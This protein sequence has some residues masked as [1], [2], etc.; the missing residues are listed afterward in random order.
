MNG[1]GRLGRT[2]RFAV[3]RRETQAQKISLDEGRLLGGEP[4]PRD[5]HEDEPKDPIRFPLL[6]KALE[7][8]PLRADFI[9][10]TDE[11]SRRQNSN[12]TPSLIRR[13]GAT[14]KVLWDALRPSRRFTRKE[15]PAQWLPRT[16]DEAKQHRILE[17][18][19][20]LNG[21][22][23]RDILWFV[24]QTPAVVALSGGDGSVL[25]SHVPEAAGRG[26]KRECDI[27]GE[28]ALFDV[29]HDGTLDLVA[30]I[31]V[32]ETAA[33]C[34]KRQAEEGKTP[35][36]DPDLLYFRRV[37]AA[38]SGQKGSALWSH[39]IDKS[40]AASRDELR[41]RP[42][43]FVKAGRRA[44]LAFLEGS[45]WQ[46]LDPETGRLVAGPLELGFEP[47]RPIL[48]ADCDG[49]GE[50][51][52]LALGPNVLGP[53]RELH[54]FSNKTG[55]ELWATDIG[56]A[57]DQTA[58]VVYPWQRPFKNRPVFSE[59]SLAADLDADGRAEIVVADTGAMPPLAGER[60]VRLIDGATG[61][62]RW[63]VALR[64]ENNAEDGVSFLLEAPDLDGDGVRDVIAVSRYVGRSR[65]PARGE[66]PLEPQRVFVDALSGKGGRRLW[67][68]HVD[69]AAGVDT[70]VGAPF[71]W[72][73]GPDG[74]PLLALPLGGKS[75][76]GGLAFP[77]F[78]R[79]EKPVVHLVEATTGRLRHSVLGLEQAA[80]ADLNGDGLADLWGEVDGE[81]RA[82]RGE[83]PEAWRALGRFDPAG[84]V[85][86]R[87]GAGVI[88]TVDLNGDGV[89]DTLICD[90]K[91]PGPANEDRT[92]SHT[93][94]ARSGRDGRLIWKTEIDP[95]RSWFNPN[96]GDAYVLRRV[97]V[98]C[99][100][101]GRRRHCRRG[102]H[103]VDV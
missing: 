15:D 59:C 7:M 72:S 63:R 60:G 102:R 80:I 23:T 73:R 47:V 12:S 17:P 90:V 76:F 95:R 55:R 10:L 100:R 6:I 78:E 65:A 66:R 103:E 81:L 92:G 27:A 19:V 21:D 98:A 67:F 89:A 87:A 56:S 51:E 83:V 37:V 20:D 68:W 39:A 50:P 13:D 24:H 34:Q 70:R 14:G 41:K 8:S 36:Q 99:G 88:H 26:E 11:A 91:A 62:S 38:V 43:M 101:S 71:W 32:G 77:R 25:W 54:A 82:F 75:L 28:P 3:N 46:G 33:E 85:D 48:H 18:A 2:Y 31:L 52:V 57:Y 58:G 69:L 86:S 64:P 22:G 94:V 93:A 96:S 84:A 1:K 42:G 79:A 5:F 4:S 16:A 49:D 61:K 45:I 74:W 40:F 9:E 53:L 30:T 29:D 97:S 44:L 35:A